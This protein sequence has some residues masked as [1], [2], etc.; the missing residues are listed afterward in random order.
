ME[1]TDCKHRGHKAS[2][3]SRSRGMR[4]LSPAGRFGCIRLPP[5]CRPDRPRI[6]PIRRL[7]RKPRR[8]SSPLLLPKPFVSVAR[9]GR[10]ARRV[11]ATRSGTRFRRDPRMRGVRA[12]GPGR[13]RSQFSSTTVNRPKRASFLKNQRK[14]W[15]AGTSPAMTECYFN[16]VRPRRSATPPA[17]ASI[18]NAAARADAASISARDLR[19]ADLPQSLKSIALFWNN[20]EMP[21]GSHGLQPPRPQIICNFAL[22]GDAYS[23]SSRTVRSHQVAPWLSAGPSSHNAYP[24]PDAQAASPVIPT[25]IIL[26]TCL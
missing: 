16:V 24:W 10:G 23:V 9:L 7:M 20:C 3:T 2:A 5:G 11:V 14:T 4:I 17:P 12:E 21:N 18:R 22:A 26:A 8:R 15:M 6:T 13:G 19:D 25:V 1:A